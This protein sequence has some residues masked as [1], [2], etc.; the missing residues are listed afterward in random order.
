M[1]LTFEVSD[2]KGFYKTVEYTSKARTTK[3]PL[4][5]KELTAWVSD[6]EKY[7]NI[8]AMTYSWTILKK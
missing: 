3:S 8:T 7:F 5:E 1:Q 4:I 2:K 6:T